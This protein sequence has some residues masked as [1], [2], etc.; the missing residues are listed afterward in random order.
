MS[1]DFL[2]TCHGAFSSVTSLYEF[3]NSDTYLYEFINNFDAF[4]LVQQKGCMMVC[5]MSLSMLDEG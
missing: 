4:K 3:N 2:S 1:S 5:F